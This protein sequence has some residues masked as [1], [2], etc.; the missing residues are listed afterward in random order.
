MP[1]KL[2]NKR[3]HM[4][5]N[6][7]RT[8]AIDTIRSET[9]LGT[10]P[11]VIDRLLEEHETLK[12]KASGLPVATYETIMNDP[13]GT[14][15]VITGIPGLGKT[16]T[17]MAALQEADRKGIPFFLIDT[18]CE[19][20]WVKR[21]LDFMGASSRKWLKEGYGPVRFTPIQEG[22]ES[23]YEVRKVIEMLQHVQNS[24]DLQG[25][26]FAVEEAHRFRGIKAFNDF[27]I[28][29]RKWTKKIIIC[30]TIAEYFPMCRPL[31]PLPRQ[32]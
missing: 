18:V 27:V 21:T 3:S 20:G 12:K 16:F 6:F 23:I 19:H 9:G 7:R 11:K 8:E 30:S 28:E 2:Q 4:M 15:V 29:G 26:I 13:L 14:P 10:R 24:G 22:G 1:E 25:H 31:S 32:T 17:M 5:L